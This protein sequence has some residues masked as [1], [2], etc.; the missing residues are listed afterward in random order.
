MSFAQDVKLSW[1]KTPTEPAIGYKIY[2]QSAPYVAGQWDGSGSTQGNSPI[3]VG[4][5]LTYQITNLTDD[6][7]YYFTVTAYDAEANEST[8]S[9]IVNSNRSG[10]SH[11]ILGRPGARVWRQED[12]P[13]TRGRASF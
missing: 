9:N 11:I 8:Y 13:T 7:I 1:D 2:Y 12:G 5:V 10:H 6:V 3:D 4:N